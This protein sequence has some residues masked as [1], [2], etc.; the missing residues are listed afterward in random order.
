MVEHQIQ[1]IKPCTKSSLKSEWLLCDQAHLRQRAP[2]P[3]TIESWQYFCSERG[4]N[5]C[6]NGNVQIVL[7][8]SQHDSYFNFTCSREGPKRMLASRTQ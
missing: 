3:E 1:M 4:K 2:I 5:C 8:N 6:M 7:S